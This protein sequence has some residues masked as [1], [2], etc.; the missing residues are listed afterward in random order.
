[1]QNAPSIWFP[2]RFSILVPNVTPTGLVDEPDP[3][4]AQIRAQS[5]PGCKFLT[6]SFSQPFFMHIRTCWGWLNG[7]NYKTAVLGTV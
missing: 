1:M 7:K 2:H 3:Q 5:A 6:F 4:G